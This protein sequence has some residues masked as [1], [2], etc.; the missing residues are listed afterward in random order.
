MFQVDK[1]LSCIPMILPRAE[2]DPQREK[3][4]D[5]E[6]LETEEDDID[7]GEA[8]LQSIDPYY[9]GQLKSLSV[10]SNGSAGQTSVA[11]NQN[12]EIMSVARLLEDFE[13]SVYSAP[14]L[15]Q[16]S[17]ISLITANRPSTAPSVLKAIGGGEFESHRMRQL[18]LDKQRRSIENL[19]RSKSGALRPNNP[20]KTVTPDYVL[21][22]E[23]LRRDILLYP[24]ESVDSK[25]CMVNHENSLEDELDEFNCCVVQNSISTLHLN[26][27]S[28]TSNGVDPVKD[29]RQRHPLMSLVDDDVLIVQ[30]SR[31]L[32]LDLS[33]RGIG[34]D[35]GQCLA[36]AL[37]Y[38]PHLQILKLK[39]NR[40]NDITLS[41]ILQAAFGFAQLQYLDFSENDA[42]RQTSAVL[43]NYIESVKNTEERTMHQ[44][45]GTS[46]FENSVSSSVHSSTKC[47]LEYIDMSHCNVG[48]ELSGKIAGA[49]SRNDTIREFHISANRI[50]TDEVR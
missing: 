18:I 1:T 33:N 40:L 10:I 19:Y 32:S 38:C 3:Y 24:S 21:F 4:V 41:V 25:R 34:P 12:N 17:K 42:H 11:S 14:Y 23:S 35:R 8:A 46:L 47:V 39:N 29:Y 5:V 44:S 16:S 20:L 45:L 27:N 26:T 37:Q 2:L 15:K 6:L 43:C 36:V 50:G 49:L 13:A 22:V 9:S 31:I 7:K 48:D 28:Q 30:N